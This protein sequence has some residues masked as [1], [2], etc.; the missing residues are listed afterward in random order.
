MCSF[1]ERDE[2]PHAPRQPR[3]EDGGQSPGLTVSSHSPGMQ[4]SRPVAVDHL[5]TP[6]KAPPGGPVASDVNWHVQRDTRL[7]IAPW[8]DAMRKLRFVLG[9]GAA[10]HNHGHKLT[11]PL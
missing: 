8:S 1:I 7:S 11:H 6:P 3:H 9:H 4:G 5:T 2:P 10:A